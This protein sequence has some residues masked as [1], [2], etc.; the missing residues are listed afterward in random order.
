V[1]A[2]CAQHPEEASHLGHCL[3]RRRLDGAE[4]RDLALLAGAEP[5]PDRLCLDGNDADR[6]RD[7]VVELAGNPRPLL[8]NCDAS[9]LIAFPGEGIR[10]LFERR[11]AQ[12]ASLERPAHE[13][14]PADEQDDPGVF[15]GAAPVLARGRDP[16]GSERDGATDEGSSKGAMG[17]DRVDGDQEGDV[18]GQR[19]LGGIRKERLDGN[20]PR[21]DAHRYQRRATA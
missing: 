6:V 14:G 8:G 9:L 18:L 4:V 16:A 15:G 1:I 20:G 7:D 11:C 3:P 19:R 12:A 5:P 17:A 13:P 21:R 2:I 10:E